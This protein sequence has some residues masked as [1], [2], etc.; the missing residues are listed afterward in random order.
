MAPRLLTPDRAAQL[1][2]QPL[3]YGEVGAT[4]TEPAPPPGY[5]GLTLARTIGAGP[6]D[7]ARAVDA[8]LSWQMHPR[9]GVRVRASDA[10]IGPD[11]VAVLRLGLGPLS[12]RAPV[13]VAYLVGD[14]ERR[15][16]A[17]GTLPGHPESGEE[18][19]VVSLAEDGAVVFE[20]SAF[21]RPASV[22]TRFGGPLARLVQR[23]VARRYLS[24]LQACVRRDLVR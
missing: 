12:L 19:F 18:A 21:S 6:A 1:R 14:P 2:G 23:L 16:F 4:R 22:L 3:N 20:V 8:L 11:T 7:F 5:H 9:A 15:G 13:R 24:A 10:R 17:Y